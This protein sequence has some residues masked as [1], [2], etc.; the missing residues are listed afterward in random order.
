MIGK[1][2][3]VKMSDLMTAVEASSGE[4]AVKE[5]KPTS[6]RAPS[7]CKACGELVK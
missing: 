6:A 3:L 2:L 7:K 5:K 4:A 1:V